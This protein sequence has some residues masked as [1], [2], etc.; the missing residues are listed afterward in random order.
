MADGGMKL[1]H[2]TTKRAAAEGSFTAS[3]APPLDDD[4]QGL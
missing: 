3:G 2:S 4:W 1:L